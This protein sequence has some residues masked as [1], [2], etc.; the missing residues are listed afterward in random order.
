M[1]KYNVIDQF[2]SL[3]DLEV[4]IRKW[5]SLP[6]EFKFRSDEECIRQHGC[7]NVVLYNN[8]KS[9]FLKDIAAQD[10][11]TA[12]SFDNIVDIIDADK[13]EYSS[14]LNESPYIALIYPSKIMFDSDA[15]NS[16]YKKY[17]LLNKKDKRISNQYS[18]E[19]WG[20][21]VP[22]MYTIMLEKIKNSMPSS[23]QPI[24][25]TE[26]E[27]KLSEGFKPFYMK[28]ILIS[29]ADEFIAEY[30]IESL[31]ALKEN[32]MADESSE[33]YF[34]KDIID[35]IDEAIR[36]DDFKSILP[37]ICPWYT[38]SEVEQCRINID[39]FDSY[40]EFRTGLL[41]ATRKLSLATNKKQSDAD[42][43]YECGWSAVPFTKNYEL[44]SLMNKAKNKQAKWL[45]E[46][47]CKIIISKDIT[48]YKRE[49]P[50]DVAPVF[51]MTNDRYDYRNMNVAIS[52]DADFN[53]GFLIRKN[54][55]L[56]LNPS[57]KF[58]FFGGDYEVSGFI[59][60]K[61]VAEDMFNGLKSIS[62][63]SE[64]IPAIINLLL[65]SSTRVEYTETKRL[66]YTEIIAMLYKIAGIEDSFTSDENCSSCEC[67]LLYRDSNINDYNP[68]K[69]Y[70]KLL[71]NYTSKTI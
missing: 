67:Y 43:I 52:F 31:E 34:G 54:T 8:L 51:I 61:D 4:D 6:Y 69:A 45:L 44:G 41:E 12:E 37:Q 71:N 53:D 68:D 10:Q 56:K 70:Q 49:F 21:N 23:G 50:D 11:V 47:C 40:K 33:V 20:Y 30:D 1:D 29:E 19:L 22:N 28:D 65:I 64:Y 16:A 2:D 13:I 18:F 57:L 14:K 5:L 17:I 36:A 63:V 48:S 27:N 7:T 38:E 59:V 24:L 35:Y 58:E 26:E 32:I 39:K 55:V 42:R 46:N 66:F 62:D 25:T 3:D 9:D 60:S 15:L